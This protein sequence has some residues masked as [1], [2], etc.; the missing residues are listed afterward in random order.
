[1]TTHGALIFIAGD[2]AHHTDLVLFHGGGKKKP[3]EI[4]SRKHLALLIR[5][6]K[7]VIAPNRNKLQIG[8]DCLKS[9]TSAGSTKIAGND[10]RHGNIF[11]WKHPD[12]GKMMPCTRTLWIGTLR[13]KLHELEEEIT[14]LVLSG[15]DHCKKK[16]PFPVGAGRLAKL[17]VIPPPEAA[18]QVPLEMAD[19]LL[20]S[21][22]Q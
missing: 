7:D 4:K 3:D 10:H 16:I 20:G 15:V 14:E 2:K 17:L 11:Y 13:D 1:M 5:A 8:I 12:T 9:M 6:Y 19:Q 18:A 22:K 21:H